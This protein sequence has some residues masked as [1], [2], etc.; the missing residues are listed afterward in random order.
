VRLA[1]RQRR[2]SIRQSNPQRGF[3][4]HNAD[5]FSRIISLYLQPPAITEEARGV[6]IEGPN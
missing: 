5:S 3:E 6:P 2:T 4:Y 1:A